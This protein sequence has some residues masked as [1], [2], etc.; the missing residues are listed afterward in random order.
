MPFDTVGK[1]ADPTLTEIIGSEERDSCLDEEVI[2]EIERG[3]LC[4]GKLLRRARV[5][6]ARKKGGDHDK[7]NR[8]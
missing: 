1:Q 7:S 3:Y 4:E 6:V 5:K 8:N 2:E